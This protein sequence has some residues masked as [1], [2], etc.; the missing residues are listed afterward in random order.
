MASLLE[1]L[2]AALAPGIA[3]ER[4]I[5]RGGMGI[6]FL[7]HD[8]LLD[9]PV[10][11]K[12]L[13]PELTTASAAQR[14]LREARHAAGLRLPNVVQV[15]HAGEADGL[16]Y[17]TM[18][19]ITGETLAAR[20]ERGPL[21][22]R[23]VVRLGLDLLAALGA[24]HGRNLIHRDVKPSNIFLVRGRAL[25]GDFG[26]A[27]ALDTTS[28]ALTQP[29]HPV[30][31]LAYISPE[32]LRELP[33]T[34]RTDLYAVGLVLYEA[35]TGRRWQP[36]TEPDRG[37]WSGVPRHMRAPIRRALQI[38]PKDR[39]SGVAPF[40]RA[41]GARERRSR[42]GT[43]AGVAA[44]IA[45]AGLLLATYTQ[46][47]AAQ[48]DREAARDLVVFPFTTVGLPDSSLGPRLAALT[49]WSLEQFEGLTLAPRQIAFR[50]WRGSSLLPARRLAALTGE[51]TGTRYGAWGVVRPRGERLE[52]QLSIVGATGEPVFES[53]VTGLAADPAAL[54]DSIARAITRAVFSRM[55]RR[56]RRA[57]AL[58]RVGPEAVNHF[59]LGEEAFAR[60]AWLTAERHYLR[61]FQLDSSF[62]LAGWRLGN[63]RRWLPLRTDPPYPP[64]LVDLFRANREAVPAVD[65]HL[66]EAQ[67]QP[68]G[69]PRYRQYEQAMLVAGDDPYAPLLY[70]DELFHRGPLA[71]RSLRDAVRLLERAVATDSTLAPAW[72]HLAWA[73][74]RLGEGERAGMALS[75]L[76]RWAAH[77]GESEI[78]LPTFLRMAYGF[79]FGDPARQR[80]VTGALSRSPEALALAARGAL[81][82]DLPAAQASLGA[83]LAASG[84]S[85]EQR[86]SGHVARGVALVA[87]GRPA[88]AQV[89]FDSASALFHDPAEARLQAAEWR[90]I[91]SALGLAGW[92]AGQRERGRRT[93]RAIT[94]DLPS[95]ER[96][97]WA[98][99]VDA[100]GR[101]DTTEATRLR[102]RVI[103][104][105]R[106]G[107]LIMML[108]GLWH[109]ARGDWQAA[110]VATEPALAFDSA[111]HAPDPFLRAA[112]H[113]KRGEWLERLGRAIDADRSWLWYENLDVR[114]W[115]HAEAQPAEVDWA[116]GTHARAR[117]ARLALE[118]GSRAEG[119]ALAW[120]VGEIWARAEP[121]V[122]S[123]G[124]ELAAMARRCHR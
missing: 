97:M 114:G 36:L 30:G 95:H 70:G 40:A 99:A 21:Q 26:V 27:Y 63:A 105:G 13:K 58:G 81:S 29:G 54:G 91:P 24:A 80:E 101:G 108:T 34:E 92:S 4:E 83:A 110:L 6:V 49:G 3:V 119:C 8:T 65:R 53:T 38:E 96:A 71:G 118:R 66:I 64:N 50:A 62:V 46:W 87:L 47:N 86:A 115:P 78:Q 28:S 98:L 123:V 14:F 37:D 18:D 55:D 100:Y 122:A 45:L 44:A 117:R 33:V 67:F 68:S 11:I 7:G 9:R 59:L 35:V 20:L 32:Q 61:A 22:S 112:L 120:R 93:L 79:R 19:Y 48:P 57:D 25:L 39:W 16:H 103:A 12:L 1:R 104:L 85:P 5:A 2:R 73:L 10:A 109:A 15:H 76:D 72:E 31:T 75:E 43:M 42:A 121:A 102:D 60:N 106:E 23:E 51:R 52:V 89:S 69:A 124:R 116:L 56:S 77:P 94:G 84:G 90:V 111:G 74:I 82:F 41:L 88:A 107:S 113:L 17:Y